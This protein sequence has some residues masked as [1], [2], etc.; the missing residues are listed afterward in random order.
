MK[1]LELPIPP[2]DAPKP[3]CIVFCIMISVSIILMSTFVI[4]MANHVKEAA[5]KWSELGFFTQ[6]ADDWEVGSYTSLKVIDLTDES[7]NTRCPKDHPHEVI[8]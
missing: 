5:T 7:T 8:Y 4:G 6:I 3:T 1:A 2:P